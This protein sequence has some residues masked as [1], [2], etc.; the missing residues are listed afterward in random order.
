MWGKYVFIAIKAGEVLTFE[1]RA[2]RE[3]FGRMKKVQ[4]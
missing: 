1:D 4:G 3:L 2:L